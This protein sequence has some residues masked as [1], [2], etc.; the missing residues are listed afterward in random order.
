MCKKEL[1]EKILEI[2][3][4]LTEIPKEEILSRSR[5]SDVTDARYLVIYTLYMQGVKIYKIAELTGIPDRSIYYAIN[6]FSLRSDRDG[7]ILNLWIKE[8]KERLQKLCIN[9][10]NLL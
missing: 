10:A 5:R 2:V 7:T 3:S 8:V 4:E 9:S 6:S 1:F